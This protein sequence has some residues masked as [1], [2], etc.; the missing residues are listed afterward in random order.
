MTLEREPYWV[1][2][3]RRIQQRNWKHW[4]IYN[5]IGWK[6]G[7]T[8]IYVISDPLLPDYARYVGVTNEP[9][10][11]SKALRSG[12][13]NEEL[14]QWIQTLP[15]SRPRMDIAASRPTYSEALKVETRMIRALEKAGF[16]LFNV[17]GTKKICRVK[18]NA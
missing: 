17:M 14:C 7:H 15:D 9:F 11:R 8:Y 2:D 16:D 18:E 6:E 10:R 5:E 4:L 12:L 1:R 13:C 3:W